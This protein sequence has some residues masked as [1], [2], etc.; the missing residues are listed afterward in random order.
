M[1]ETIYFKILASSVSFI[2]SVARKEQE[3][4][5]NRGKLELSNE[6]DTWLQKPRK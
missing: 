2:S 1:Q 5:R 4:Q 3:T 6:K